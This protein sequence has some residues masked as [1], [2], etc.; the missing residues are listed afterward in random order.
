M[1]KNRRINA[2]VSPAR[3]SYPWIISFLVC[4]VDQATKWLIVRSLAP[5]QSLAVFSPF[6]HLTYV[7]NTGAA[8]GLFKGSQWLF[9]LCAVLV[10]AW[11]IREL[12]R[13]Q[14]NAHLLTVSY[15]LV[16]GGAVG[17]V[18]DRLRLN[19]V[20]DFLDFRVWPVFNVG[21]SAITV[22]VA[23]LIGHTLFQKKTRYQAPK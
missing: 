11:I 7:Q 4:I 6:F 17:N 19:Y 1:R 16:L 15:A 21:D 22:G 23:L 20:I 18:I 3:H 9:L 2:R 5:N 14:T 12:L 8:F 10:A 13:G